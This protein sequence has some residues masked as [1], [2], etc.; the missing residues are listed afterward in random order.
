MAAGLN[1]GVETLDEASF[2]TSM[3]SLITYFKDK[4]GA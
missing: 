2:A 3:Q 4:L 1:P